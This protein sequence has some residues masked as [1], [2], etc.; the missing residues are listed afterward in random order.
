[1]YRSEAGSF[2]GG[3]GGAPHDEAAL[4][5]GMLRAELAA[6]LSQA[7]LRRAARLADMILER[8]DVKEKP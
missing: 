1:M 3:P 2:F 4:E 5:A 7:D 8:Y 6:L